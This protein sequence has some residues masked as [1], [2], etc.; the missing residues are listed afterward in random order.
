[1]QTA[2]A[3][4]RSIHDGRLACATVAAPRAAPRSFSWGARYPGSP[5]ADEFAALVAKDDASVG[6]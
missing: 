1:M 5:G 6:H 4:S 3:S 2:S